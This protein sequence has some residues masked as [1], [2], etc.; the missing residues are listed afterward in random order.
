MKPDKLEHEFP[1]FGVD[2][3]AGVG[4]PA[5]LFYL[6]GRIY[7]AGHG[8]AAERVLLEEGA[9]AVATLRFDADPLE[10]SHPGATVDLLAPAGAVRHLTVKAR[11]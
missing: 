9:V 7:I 6:A 2:W 8:S 4:Q 11:N 1:V 3:T 5:D 10:R